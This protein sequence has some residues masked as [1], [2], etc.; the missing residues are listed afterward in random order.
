MIK[1][2]LRADEISGVAFGSF[3]C[4]VLCERRKLALLPFHTLRRRHPMST[5]DCAPSANYRKEGG[6]WSAK[7]GTNRLVAAMVPIS[8]DSGTAFGRCGRGNRNARR[9]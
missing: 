9:Q 6:V 3:D 8:N 5:S 7:G 4:V 2:A 1:A